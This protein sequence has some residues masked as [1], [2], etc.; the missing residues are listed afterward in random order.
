MKTLLIQF[1]VIVA[2]SISLPAAAQDVHF[3]QMQYSPMLLNPGL[4]GAN[5]PLQAIVNYRSQWNSVA[6]PYKTINASVDGRFNER[7]RTKKGIFAGGINFFND[8]V[9]DLKVTTNNVNVNLAY[10][11]ILDRRQT[12]GIGIYGG[13]TQRSLSGDEGRWG[14]QYNGT[15]YDGTMASGEAFNT[16]NF[17]FIDAGTG[18]VYT[19]KI[20]EGYMTQN[21]QK[22]VNAGVAFYHVNSPKY[23]FINS[24]DEKLPMR[25][26]IFANAVLGFNNSNGALLPG[27]YFNRQKSNMEILYGTYYRFQLAEGSHVTGRNKPFYFALGLFHRWGDAL[28]AKSMLEYGPVSGG[29][30][31]DI[32]ISSL[33]EVSRAQG[34][35]ELFLRYNMSAREGGSR[36]MIR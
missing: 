22:S 14:S 9:G 17:S 20:N 2:V 12:L 30:A 21:N 1:L 32:N 34:G 26:S 19:Y 18:L 31:Y 7:S 24:E 4:A 25:W 23:S 10:H 15:A 16:P 36:S 13:F 8:Q 29:F 6:S 11:L 5:S 35:F 33:T 3:S 28:V 27:V